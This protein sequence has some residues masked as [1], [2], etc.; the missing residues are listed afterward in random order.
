MPA[1]PPAVGLSDLQRIAL[2][3]M[4]FSL[5]A[6]NST[7]IY[8]S[9]GI[10]C[11]A[12]VLLLI[13]D[14]MRLEGF[15]FSIYKSSVGIVIIW[16]VWTF[17][18]LLS[19]VANFRIVTLST[20]AWSYA[21]PLLMIVTVLTLRP[22]TRDLRIVF[23]AM[24]AGWVIRFGYGA[25]VF[26]QTMGFGSVEQVLYAHFDLESFRPYANATY[27]STGRTIALVVPALVATMLALFTVKASNIE[28]IFIGATLFILSIT[29]LITGSRALVIVVLIVM[30]LVLL[31]L[32]PL[33]SVTVTV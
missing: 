17:V 5:T 19:M 3:I 8:L 7:P 14:H 13:A 4:A 25:F 15:Q 32:Q 24:L 29:A 27:G 28:R 11:A 26:G 18:A 2:I 6:M 20:F 30:V 16:S 22:T 23:F 1:A 31:F 21:L 10:F 33:L 9:C 12:A